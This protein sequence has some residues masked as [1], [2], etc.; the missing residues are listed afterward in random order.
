MIAF[1]PLMLSPASLIFLDLLWCGSVNLYTKSLSSLFSIFSSMLYSFPSCWFHFQH[2]YY[3]LWIASTNLLLYLKYVLLLSG[4]KAEEH[5]M[6][7][8]L[9]RLRSRCK[10]FNIKVSEVNS[11]IKVNMFLH[12]NYSFFFFL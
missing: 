2:F 5:L 7:F 1:V 10:M 11:I 8:M 9:T 12:S 6:K 3:L 4:T